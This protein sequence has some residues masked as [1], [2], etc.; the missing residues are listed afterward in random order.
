MRWVKRWKKRYLYKFS[1]QDL[2]TPHS[3]CSIK[4]S[5]V[6]KQRWV[7]VIGDSPV[8]ETEAPTCRPNPLF[9][10]VCCFPGVQ[11]RD[12]T[13]KFMSLV[14]LS[15][16]CRLL[17]FQTGTIS[18]TA[19]LKSIKRD[20]RVLGR[21]LKDSEAQEVFSSTLPHGK[22]QANPGYQCLPPR[23]VP[24]PEFWGL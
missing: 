11:I 16:Y 21:W 5:A 18:V 7:A 14:Q 15:D 10:E 1:H 8:K 13:S 4:T 6:K 2:I 23:L 22:K 20:F 3:K 9:R 12:I 24:P 17:L 19:S